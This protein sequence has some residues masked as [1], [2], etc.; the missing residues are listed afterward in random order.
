MWVHNNFGCAISNY[1]I[2]THVTFIQ[3]KTEMAKH[4]ADHVHGEKKN[5]FIRVDMSEYQEKSNVSRFIGSAPGYVG[6]E[7]GGIL[8]NALMKAPNAVVL[9]D[10]V[11]KAHTDVLTIMLQL[12][13]EVRF[14]F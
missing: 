3:G 6:Y 13:D 4:V 2:F 12:F 9:F 14:L 10:E 1:Y 7:E 8:T 5:H 11:E